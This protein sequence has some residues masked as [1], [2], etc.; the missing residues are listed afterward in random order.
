MARVPI[1]ATTSVAAAPLTRERVRAADNEGGALG[2]FSKGAAGAAQALS[3]HSDVQEQLDVQLDNAATKRQ[4]N[5]AAT[6]L[7][8]LLRTG[9]DAYFSKQGFVAAN[10][11][12]PTEKAISDIRQE[13]L[14]GLTT[15]RQRD[16]FSQSFDDRASSELVRIA[17]HANREI[18]VEEGRQSVARMSNAASDAVIHADEPELFA[19]FVATGLG[20]I[21]AKAAEH[22]PDATRAAKKAYVSNI[23]TQVIDQ[24]MTAD[25]EAAARSYRDNYDNIEPSDRLKIEKALYH[26]LMERQGEADGDEIQATLE[27]GAP[28]IET[29]APTKGAVK[30]VAN[31]RAVVASVYPG[32]R[33][34]SNYRSPDDPLSKANPTSWHTQ[35]H[36]AVDVAP[37]KGMSFEQYVGGLKRAGYTIIEAKNEVGS[38][39]SAHATG[40]HWHVVVG[41]PGS[42]QPAPAAPVGHPRRDDLGGLYQ[43]IDARSDWSFERK[44]FARQAI[45]DRVS[46]N[47]RV[48]ARSEEYAKDE[49]YRH[50]DAL[51]DD[52]TSVSQ[53][54]AAVRRN[55]SAEA[56]HSLT[57]QARQN[58]A[59][60]PVEANGEVVTNLHQLIELDPDAFR[61]KDLRLYKQSMTRA[62]YDQVSTLQA[63]MIA[64][65][66]APEAVAH[67]RIWGMINRYAVD[68]NLD[69]K[70]TSKEGKPERKE[71]MRLFSVMQNYITALTGGERQPTDDELKKAFDNAVMPVVRGGAAIAR[72]RDDALPTNSVAIP[73]A[74]QE[75]LRARRKA[76][77]LPYDDQTIARMYIQGAR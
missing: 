23:W 73:R 50:I 2:G 9:E 72:F 52:Y 34:T 63:R 31:G 70:Q 49:A 11:R 48:I 18:G 66:N 46:R 38:G 5:I 47:D 44:K 71:A 62:E 65:P 19:R 27:G 1:I 13:L 39:R 69:M 35:S 58:A 55:L 12:K 43:A 28:R 61:K 33:I 51:G 24:K 3:A 20:E 10:A 40:D 17:E 36:G 32:A 76:V 77:G 45:E 53:I 67:S 7:R 22:G 4:D 41:Q 74:V 30:P 8:E 37:I 29:A 6:R 59:P 68:V 21:E 57:N 16:M 64:K 15:R 56:L 25:P 75:S 60:K 42:G 26:P 14:S 54:P